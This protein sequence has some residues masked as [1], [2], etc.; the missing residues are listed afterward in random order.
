MAPRRCT[1]VATALLLAALATAGCGLGPG[2]EVGSVELTVT[3][4]FGSA[5]VLE[6][7]V[8]GRESDTVMR[9]LES[10]AEISTRYGGGFVQSID[11]VE[12]GQRGGD[13]HD[14]FFYVDGVESPVGAADSAVRG[15]EKIWWDYRDWSAAEHVPAVVGSWPAPFAEGYE[16]RR[17]PVALECEG[18][19]AACGRARRALAGAGADLAGGASDAVRVLVGPWSRLRTDPAAAQLDGGPQE[20]GVFAEFVRA[21]GGYRL[22]ALDENGEPGRELGPDAGLVAATR[23][24]ESPPVWLVTG[25]TPA[26][27]SAAAGLLSA[28]KL[29]DRYAVASEAGAEIR[30]PEA[31][32][33][34]S[35]GAG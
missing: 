21:G 34:G 6:R 8:E 20:S 12:G 2:G 3:R 13:P 24:Y 16:G 14:W 33:G 11:G 25:A 35:G 18:G 5:P 15:G 7:S 28:A 32:A 31:G 4:E 19:G 27:V 10:S 26:G 9:V 29:R 23:R 1:A 22:R 17:H 30:L